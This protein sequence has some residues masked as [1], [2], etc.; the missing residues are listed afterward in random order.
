[1]PVPDAL[2][3]PPCSTAYKLT[4]LADDTVRGERGDSVER[5]RR[6]HAAM[7][8]EGSRQEQSSGRSVDDFVQCSAEHFSSFDKTRSLVDP[9]PWAPLG[10]LCLFVPERVVYHSLASRICSCGRLYTIV[11]VSRLPET[12][13]ESQ[14]SARSAQ[15]PHHPSMQPPDRQ[16]FDRRAI[17]D[18]PRARQSGI[19]QLGIS[20]GVFVES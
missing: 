9:G 2:L 19:C 14:A 15:H 20:Y 1:M 8:H 6:A 5:V 11:A 4:C 3:F 17:A 13:S 16:A 7:P 12:R 18:G 10:F